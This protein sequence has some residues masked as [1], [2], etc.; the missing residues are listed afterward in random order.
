[1]RSKAHKIEVS[2]RARARGLQ[3]STHNN[4]PEPL[5]NQ[6]Q[7]APAHAGCNAHRDEFMALCLLIV[8]IRA[9]ARGLQPHDRQDSDGTARFNSRPRTRAAT[10]GNQKRNLRHP[11]TFQF[12]PAHAGCNNPSGFFSSVVALFQFAPAHAGCNLPCRSTFK[13]SCRF[14]SR[15]RTRAAT[16]VLVGYVAAVSKQSFNSR[17]RTR[18]ATTNVRRCARGS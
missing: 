13:S 5:L 6:F 16:Y 11:I 17:P 15:P 10:L 4:Q 12:A 1:M 9:R 2:I 3:L 18:A 14:N 7:F 8:S